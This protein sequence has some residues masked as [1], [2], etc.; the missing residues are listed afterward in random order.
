MGEMKKPMTY[1]KLIIL[2]LISF[3]IQ[4]LE[5]DSIEFEKPQYFAGHTSFGDL[6]GDGYN[7]IFV[8]EL[9]HY[10]NDCF[11]PLCSTPIDIHSTA[12]VLLNDTKGGFK[13]LQQE[14]EF[15]GSIFSSD[16]INSLNF[17]RS[18]IV[19]VNND[20]FNDIVASNGRVFVNDG[21]AQFAVPVFAGIGSSK[22]SI[23][24]V[25][26]NNDGVQ[27][28]FNDGKIR[29]RQSL[30]PLNY[31][32]V[33][34]FVIDSTLDVK[35]ADFNNDGFIDIIAYGAGISITIYLNNQVGVFSTANN[36]E[37]N[38]VE[39]VSL[40][41]GDLDGDEK[42]DIV[43]SDNSILKNEGSLMFQKIENAI[44]LER[45]L[46]FDGNINN[47]Y[48][49]INLIKYNDDEFPDLLIRTYSLN[50]NEFHYVLLNDGQGKFSISENIITSIIG[51]ENGVVLTSDFNNDNHEDFIIQSLV[52]PISMIDNTGDVDPKSY[53]DPV[54]SMV[55]NLQISDP[56]S[57]FSAPSAEARV[58]FS[59]YIKFDIDNDGKN[60]YI[61]QYY[62][63]QFNNALQNTNFAE[64]HGIWG[65]EPFYLS[66]INTSGY[67]VN[68]F[69][70]FDNELRSYYYNVKGDFNSDGLED[71]LVNYIGCNQ[72]CDMRQSRIFYNSE[73]GLNV[74]NKM[75]LNYWFFGN[76][77]DLNGDGENE[78]VLFSRDNQSFETVMRIV[79]L[80]VDGLNQ[81]LEIELGLTR[82]LIS[83]NDI[84]NDGKDDIIYL[85]NER[86]PTVIFGD[87]DINI[88]SSA[89]ELGSKATENFKLYD[90]DFDGDLD[91]YTIGDDKIYLYTNNGA[92]YFSAPHLIK[93]SDE[94]SLPGFEFAD[95]NNDGV[96]E[97][98]F[99]YNN[100]I[101]VYQ[102]DRQGV[103]Q[104][105]YF[106]VDEDIDENFYFFPA[107]LIDD[108]DGDD[109]ADILY[110]GKI[111]FSRDF[112]FL[113][114]LNYDLSHTGH[115]FSIENIGIGNQFYT[116]FYTYGNDGFPE[117]YVDLGIFRKTQDDY[118]NI[119]SSSNE[120]IRFEYDYVNG[121]SFQSEEDLYRGHLTHEKCMD[122]FGSVSLSFE[123]NKSP[124]GGFTE[125]GDWCSEPIVSYYQRPKDNLSGLWWAGETDSGWGW[126]VSL[127]E[128]ESVTDIVLVL[129]YY[130]GEGNPRWLMGQQADF[131]RGEEITINMNMVK[132]Y[133]RNLIPQNLVFLPAGTITLTLIEASH[134]LSTAGVMSVNVTYPGPEGGSWIRDN[135]P[136]ALFSNARH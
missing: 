124:W 87:D 16:R 90:S 109:K 8:S 98:I 35:F 101:S 107:V 72:Q 110:N 89:V 105:I 104:S 62:Y 36:V 19:D 75:D 23:Y 17:Y 86:K 29:K 85:N 5:F 22:N 121:T 69:N 91:L 111:M 120:L 53:I 116:V 119:A 66:E 73:H 27:E 31:Q 57:Q 10:F 48:I 39:S 97:I 96:A 63:N 42:V 25:D 122:S 58:A 103:F 12:K 135:I 1:I 132:G 117:W 100:G 95:F 82:G 55:L 2:V 79:E 59:E 99:P 129:Y 40:L 125:K 94:P 133:A 21:S 106:F 34:N 130:D 68:K 44:N 43:L 131:R 128:R 7:D 65:H 102:L 126:S 78:I 52:R 38:E 70:L 13:E 80:G 93:F 9:R 123:L 56:Q 33:D 47:K 76:V 30:I 81:I 118:W 114:G 92:G 74:D 18:V 26:F 108:F 41:I 113:P 84:N 15:G 24:A 49:P 4:S 64:N 136:I 32:V 50:Y 46:F 3:S 67:K 14:N 134:N 71:L 60:E 77:I 112:A 20:G 88:L 28:I 37:L 54:V 83:L 11:F 6:N 51:G 61:S 45:E 127:V 115:G